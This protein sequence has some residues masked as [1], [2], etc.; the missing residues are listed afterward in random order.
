MRTQLTKCQ[1]CDESLWYRGG[2]VSKLKI[3]FFYDS[4]QRE[5]THDPNIRVDTYKCKNNHTTRHEH[6]KKCEHG[7][8]EGF[9]N[10]SVL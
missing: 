8:F 10:I 4:K 1:K 6:R 2:D 5:H 9:E 3:R 7:D